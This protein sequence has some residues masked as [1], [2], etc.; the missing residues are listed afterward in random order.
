MAED[1]AE[2]RRTAA[3]TRLDAIGI[4]PRTT[5]A[6]RTRL[7]SAGDPPRSR[8]GA[9][10]LD[11]PASVEP[12]DHRSSA[13][14]SVHAGSQRSRASTP[15]PG[16]FV[17]RP[18]PPSLAARVVQE[19]EIGEG[20]EAVVYRARYKRGSRSPAVVK[21]FHNA[22]T[23]AFDLKDPEYRLHFL[24]EHTVRIFERGVES[25]QHWEIAEF[26][27]EGSL[28]DQVGTHTFSGTELLE[29]VGELCRAIASMHPFVHGDIKPSNVLI[30]SRTP[31][32]DLVL[33]DFGVTMDLGGR[34]RR[35]NLGRGTIAY[36]PPGG[37]DAFRPENDWWA[38]GMTL[39]DLVLG[40]NVFQDKDGRW[41]DDSRIGEFLATDSVPLDGVADKR[42][43]LLLS[44]LLQRN[45]R[46][47]WGENEILQWCSGKSPAVAEDRLATTPHPR[48]A[49]A[50]TDRSSGPFPF[51]GTAFYVPAELGAALQSSP[52]AAKVGRGVEL[53]ALEEW[54]RPFDCHDRVARVV[55]QGEKLGAQLTADLIASLIQPDGRPVYRTFDLSSEEDLR[56]LP[57]AF[58][59]GQMKDL[60]EL[61]PMYY[62]SSLLDLPA[63]GLLD[64]SWRDLINQAQQATPVEVRSKVSQDAL[65][66]LALIAVLQGTSANQAL[67]TR[68]RKK[69]SAIPDE[70]RKVRWFQSVPSPTADA[71][72]VSLAV[73]ALLP[74]LSE[75]AQKIVL[76][77]ATEQERQRQRAIEQVSSQITSL[78]EDTRQASPGPARI[79]VGIVVAPVLVG[80]LIAVGMFVLLLIIT[81]TSTLFPVF[82]GELDAGAAA[83][84]VVRSMVPW[85]MSDPPSDPWAIAKILLRSIYLDGFGLATTVTMLA[86]YAVRHYFGTPRKAVVRTLVLLVM[87]VVAAQ[88]WRLASG[89]MLVYASNWTAFLLI[90]AVMNLAACLD[91]VLSGTRKE[92]NA[93]MASNVR[94]IATAQEELA[95]LQKR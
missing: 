90:P 4:P 59:D 27:P 84:Y 85:A 50:T 57:R 51:D 93:R 40:R 88:P 79:R 28:Q 64:E 80:G 60:Y 45:H 56:A 41:L 44:G 73:L 26:C 67:A 21:L 89:E 38:L 33:T 25:G 49:S 46:Q 91:S 43:R 58:T 24:P 62:F 94:T 10:R 76:D 55:R 9:T 66:R 3:R 82:S 31:S 83:E 92:L 12:A 71:P 47:R 1:K 6:P 63:L 7:D 61:R 52:H 29:I 72:G 11:A 42:M 16:S 78:E 75:A 74:L 77:E 37:R 34:S 69:L 86:L 54:L 39:L 2:P 36:L 70:G 5:N 8:P 48:A 19:D 32:L 18:F 81:A 22:P 14:D 23:Y 13:P 30:R 15:A 35:T 68:A 65:R 20:G 95:R 17:R 53:S 87:I